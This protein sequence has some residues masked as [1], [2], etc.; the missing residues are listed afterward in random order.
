MRLEQRA[1]GEFAIVQRQMDGPKENGK[2]H[3]VMKEN[4]S[5]VKTM[6]NA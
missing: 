1:Q 6:M 2:T 4:V 5:L 3:G